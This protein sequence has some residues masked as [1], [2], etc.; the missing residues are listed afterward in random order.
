MSVDYKQADFMLSQLHAKADKG[1]AE[2]K[3][4][5]ALIG[6]S[7]RLMIEAST[8]SAFSNLLAHAIMMSPETLE[9]FKETKACQ[10][11]VKRLT[12]VQGD[13]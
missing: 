5:Y 1:E 11:I 10:D 12:D 8:G 6:L 2:P 13:K 3:D 4:I 9:A 7:R